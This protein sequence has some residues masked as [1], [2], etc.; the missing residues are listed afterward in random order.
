MNSAQF[1]WLYLIQNGMAGVEPAYYGGYD[2]V[3]KRLTPEKKDY[4]DYGKF[5][6]KYLHE[7][8]T[9]GVN[10]AKTNSPRS[11]MVSQ[12]E[13]TFCDSSEKEYL[14]GELV[15]NNG[16]KQSWCGESIEVTNVFDMM[17]EVHNAPDAFK[18]IFGEGV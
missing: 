12:F 6:S 3:D 4:G 11:D 17:A 8:K 16:T 5:N 7:I 10:W 2:I 13:G 15:L 18:E 9:Y 14:F 1:A